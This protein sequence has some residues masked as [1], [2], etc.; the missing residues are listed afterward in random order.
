MAQPKYYLNRVWHASWNKIS[1]E[2]IWKEGRKEGGKENKKVNRKKGIGKIQEEERKIYKMSY[3][4]W[5]YIAENIAI[6]SRGVFQIQIMTWE[7]L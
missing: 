1:V 5:S 2:N 4:I 7:K 3:V 6:A